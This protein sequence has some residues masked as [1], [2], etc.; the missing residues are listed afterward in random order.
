MRFFGIY[1]FFSYAFGSER[2]SQSTGL[3]ARSPR[4]RC[5]TAPAGIQLG[6]WPQPYGLAD[7]FQRTLAAAGL[8]KDMASGQQCTLHSLRHTY[9]TKEL[10]LGTDINTL[11]RQ[12]GTR[13]IMLERH[14]SKLT[15]TI[16]VLTQ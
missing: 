9:A 7:T 14:Y 5:Q 1:R 15:A 6:R 10:M 12:M 13:V 2:I 4:Q 11:A 8:S 3:R 16:A